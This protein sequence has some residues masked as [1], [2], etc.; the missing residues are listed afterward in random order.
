MAVAV[1]YPGVYVQELASGVRT[2]V[3]VGTSIAMFLG[4]AKLGE[5]NKPVRCL[6]YAD[7]ERNFSSVYADSDLAREVRLFYDNGGTECYVM[8]IADDTALQAS[9]MLEDEAGVDT[10]RVSARSAGLFGN[11]I[12]VA[13]NYNTT[14]PE[15]TFNMEVFRWTLASNGALQKSQGESHIGL[16]MEPGHPRYCEDVVN[17]LSQLIRVDDQ[18]KLVPLAGNGVSISGFAVSARTNAIFQAQMQALITPATNKFRLSVGGQPSALI[19]LTAIIAALPLASVVALQNLLSAT[20]NAQLSPGAVIQVVFRD[21]PTGPAAQDNAATLM[22]SIAGVNA[23][24]YIEPASQDDLAGVLM[25][26][27]AQGG[28]EIPRSS[29]RRPAPNGVVFRPGLEVT[30]NAYA[31]FGQVLQANVN[32][33]RV[34]GADIPLAGPL[35]LQTT[36]VAAVNGPRMYQDRSAT[37]QNDSGDGV[38]EKFALIA[39]AINGTHQA[40]PNFPW[41]AEVW[42]SRLAIIA[43]DGVGDLASTTLEAGFITAGVFAPVPDVFALPGQTPILNGRYYALAAPPAPPT[44]FY[45]AGVS[46]NDGGPPELKHYRNAFSIIDREVDLFNLLVLP[47]D[48]GHTEDQMRGLWGPASTFCQEKRA[49]LIMDPPP[50][51][52]DHNSATDVSIGVNTLRVGLA[53]QYAALYFPDLMVREGNKEVAVGPSGAVAG[54]MA[55]IDATRGVWKAAA[56]IEADVRGVIG[57]RRRFSDLEN[58]VMNKR[59]V[60]TIRVFPNGIVIWGARTMDGDDGFG[61]EYKYSPV[62]RVANFIEESLYRGLKWAV[63]EPNDEPLWAQIRLNVGAFMHD[64]FRQG[65][66]QGATPRDAYFVRCDRSTTTQN[67]INLGIVNVIVGF[68]PLKPAEF[69]VLYLQQMAGQIQT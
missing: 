17:L 65:A 56:G 36:S 68:A 40:D 34:A 42:G 7:F 24:V 29:A 23:D 20:I 60:N 6:S 38:R 58:G 22:M 63:F 52:V 2:I 64:L 13:I 19:D 14:L 55:R 57:V 8:R 49:F 27:T 9:V 3:G 31:N 61:S 66:F 53:K 54:V 18:R 35:A 4:R 44:A 10:L 28:I 1:S 16:S 32:A 43:A 5:L 69:V 30:P 41:A 50:S 62:R 33:V 47:R 45:N 37:N 39:A 46:G 51:W 59:A 48:A 21:G 15:A 67:D 26:G 11:D 12:R 25:L